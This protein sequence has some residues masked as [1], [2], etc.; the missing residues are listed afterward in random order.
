MHSYSCYT[1]VI[2]LTKGVARGGPGVRKRHDDVVSTLTLKQCHPPYPL[3]N[4]GYAPGINPGEHGLGECEIHLC[5][6]W[7]VSLISEFCFTWWFK[8]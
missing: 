6:G 1:V 3:K 4:P 8:S 5:L 7:S 2:R